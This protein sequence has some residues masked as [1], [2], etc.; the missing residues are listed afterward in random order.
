[1]RRLTIATLAAGM[2]FLLTGCFKHTYT[3]GEG[4]PPGSKVVYKHWHQHWVFGVIG[5]ENVNLAEI[6]PS[7]NATIHEER[8]FLNG[9]I[10]V[11]IGV[12][13]SPTTVTVMCA[14]GSRTEVLLSEDEVASII[15]DPRFL[16]AVEEHAPERLAEVL[17]ALP[18]LETETTRVAAL[19]ERP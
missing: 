19:R 16:L 12:I 9:L 6:C 4:A 14:D 2:C 13:Y 15:A 7:G 11:L 18:F 5:D 1:M 10:D 8:S 3:I 17:T